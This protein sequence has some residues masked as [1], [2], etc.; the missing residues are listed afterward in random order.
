MRVDAN[1]IHRSAVY[2][3][4]STVTPIN[5]E[6]KAKLDTYGS[7]FVVGLSLGVVSLV[8]LVLGWVQ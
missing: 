2:Y 7:V 3:L 6:L 4:I 8:R 1:E 5:H